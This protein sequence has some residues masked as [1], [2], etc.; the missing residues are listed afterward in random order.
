MSS[1]TD[2]KL[3]VHRD[4][5]DTID[6]Q[7]LELMNQRIGA[8]KCIAEIKN[9]LDQPAIY[10]PEREA[11]VLRR[12]KNLN[13]GELQDS[14]IESLFREIM[15]ITRG[16]EA[17]LSAAL[18]GPQGTFTE[19]AALQHFGSKIELVYFPTVDEICKAAETGLTDF[20]V[21]PIE[22]STEGGVS[23][24]LDRLT[25]T[26]LRICGE[27][28]LKIH[29]N[30]ISNA[31]SLENVKQVV[32][33]PQALGQCRSWISRNLAEAELIPCN[34]NT[35]G[36]L[37]ASEDDSVAAIAALTAAEKFGLNVMV[38][39]IEDEPGNTTRFLVLSDRET[40]A[41]GD[42]KTSL[43][44]SG[45]NR[46]GA[47]FHLLKPLVDANLDMTKIESRPSR[48]GLWEYVF[49][50]DVKG[51]AQDPKL[52]EALSKIKAEAGLFK[53]LGS[54]PAST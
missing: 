22:N 9:K 14:D 32:A 40:P 6:E 5:I 28:F 25:S 38:A 4:R 17:G 42:D 31:E 43:L 54:Y 30:L 41:S 51:H 33:H 19:A 3:Q 10:R 34:S 7:I 16:S 21:V 37:R 15:S 50:V 39:N 48:S 13:H 29:H 52:A 8:A 49:F 46:P 26:P 44:V 36:A 18:L 2:R 11:Q 20:A 35:E 1:D 24:T 47:L 12:L 27:I 45:R 23:A 53:L